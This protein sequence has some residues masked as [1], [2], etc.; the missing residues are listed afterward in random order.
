M[1]LAGPALAALCLAAAT[2]LA[3]DAGHEVEG[4]KSGYLFLTEGT[5]QL[6][7]DDFQ[8][9]AMFA[10]DHGRE[11]WTKPMGAEGKSCASCHGEAETSMH[12]IAAHY[13]KYDAERKGLVNLE[14]KI[15]DE[16][17]RRMKA[18]P[19]AYESEDMLAMTAFLGFQSRGEPMAVDI[20]GP[21]KPF[22]D[23][24]QAFYMQRR[25]QFDLACNQ[26]HDSLV[27]RKLRGD[28]ISQGQINGFPIYRLTWKSLA[29]RHRMFEWCNTSI[30]AEPYA[31]GSEEYLSLELYLA[32]RGRG[33]GME[34]PA[35]RR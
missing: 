18:E 31:Y 5:Q 17:A 9:P 10:V 1:R 35:V 34:T 33:L 21:T 16:I 6:Q 28:V 2:A 11:L 12:G 8:N 20:D 3:A 30:R 7:D 26:C 4:R 19:F 27:G 24:G 29:S 13:P 14:L 32:W 25:G 15:N 22:F 23:K